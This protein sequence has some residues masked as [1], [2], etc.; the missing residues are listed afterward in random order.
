MRKRTAVS[1][2]AILL[3]CTA[4]RPSRILLTPVPGEIVSMEGHASLNLSSEEG[5]GRSRFSFAVRLPD[6]G[7]ISVSN[8]LGQTLYQILADRGETYF[9]L[10]GKRAYWQ[11]EET[12]IF[13][14]FLGFSLSLSEMTALLCGE[15]A[16]SLQNSGWELDRDKNGRIQSGRRGALTFAV[17]EFIGSTS[18]AKVI[19][20]I[21]PRSE[22]RMRLIQVR[23]NT[24]LPETAFDKTLLQRFSRK[25]WEE[26][27]AI[28]YV[29]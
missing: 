19:S 2:T 13:E 22:G 3:I 21:H 7:R 5:K 4:C 9:I 29:P 14:K 26:I 17:T 11:G 16:F 10:P 23:L 24:P 27:E 15:W 18:L 1:L 6:Q 8:F 12:E 25:T 28:L 20:F